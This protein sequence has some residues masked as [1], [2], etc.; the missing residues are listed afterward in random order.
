LNISA[1]NLG[2]GKDI[3]KSDANTIWTNSD[4]VK[5]D[6][7]DFVCDFN[8]YPWTSF[9]DNQFNYILCKDV[10]EHLDNVVRAME[11][12][13]RIG[14]PG[15]IVEIH[16]PYYASKA[17]F[18]DPTHRRGFTENSLDYFAAGRKY[19]TYNFYTSARFN[20]QSVKFHTFGIRRFIPFKGI[21]RIFLLNITDALEFRVEVI[22]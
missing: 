16:V 18:T 10:L 8:S 13:Y 19:S 9:E 2:C 12:I 15:A 6:G 22:K 7:V 17:A 1:L 3:K 14:K 21:L 4:I 11:E 20:I 5:A